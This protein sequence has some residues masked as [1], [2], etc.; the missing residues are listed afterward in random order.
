MNRVFLIGIAGD[1]GSGKTTFA[2]GIRRMFHGRVAAFSMDDYHTLS[3]KERFERGIT[4]LNPEMTD[5]EL[6][7]EHLLMLKCGKAIEKPVYDHSLGERRC[8]ERFEPG[9]IVIAEGL[10]T[11]YEGLNELYDYRIFVDPAREIKRTW[12]LKRDVEERGYRRE[13]VIREIIQREPDYKRFVDF[14][15]IYADTIVKIYPSML[16]SSERISYLSSQEEMYRVRLVFTNLSVNMKHVGLKLDL[17]RMIKA[18]ER[19]FAISFFSD[20]YYGKRAS[21][22]D[23]DGFLSVEIFQS[24]LDV[25]RDETGEKLEW[26]VGEYASSTEIAKLM[27]CWNLVEVMNSEKI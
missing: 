21:F 3:R 23:V 19:D 14:Q 12:K 24:L 9:E 10:H 11:L 25:L 26:D 27:I 17:S 16:K 4:P 20:Y 1:S 5:L 2:E 6:F 15:K 22:I 13:D 7:R 8:C 18:G